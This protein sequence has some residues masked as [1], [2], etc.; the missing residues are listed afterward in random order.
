VRH[1]SV[2]DDVQA[3]ERGAQT[4]PERLKLVQRVALQRLVLD[5]KI[6]T[7]QRSGGLRITALVAFGA[8]V[9]EVDEGR[10]RFRSPDSEAAGDDR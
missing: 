10:G 5:C 1:V 2:V 9:E 8:V 7:R 3:V 6:E 4:D